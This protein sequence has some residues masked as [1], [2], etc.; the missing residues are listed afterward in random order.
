MLNGQNDK[1]FESDYP[2]V[3]YTNAYLQSHPEMQNTNIANNYGN[4][5]TNSNTG[6]SFNAPTGIL[7]S[8]LNSNLL[9]ELLPALLGQGKAG[10][11]FDI[12]SLLKNFNPNIGQL[13][14]SLGVLNKG[15]KKD[16]KDSPKK[17]N[18][19]IDLSDYEK[20]D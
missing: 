10:S 16:I 5:G 11:G 7:G 2:P 6:N 17:E 15:E 12:A 4:Q 14:N 13:I 3:F 9:R 1:Q 8:I 20:I 18:T 19:I